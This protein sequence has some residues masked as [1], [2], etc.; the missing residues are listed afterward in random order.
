M[1]AAADFAEIRRTF[2]ASMDAAR[3]CLINPA[4]ARTAASER[5][6]AVPVKDDGTEGGAR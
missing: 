3:A 4:E 5:V 1:T 2:A 6:T